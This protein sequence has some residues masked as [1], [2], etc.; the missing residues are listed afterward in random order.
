MDGEAKIAAL[1][2]VA[3]GSVLAAPVLGRLG[4]PALADVAMWL[5]AGSGVAAF[6]VAGSATWRAA[7]RAGEEGR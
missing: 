2:L 6:A 4:M 7:R 1:V 5:A 3:A